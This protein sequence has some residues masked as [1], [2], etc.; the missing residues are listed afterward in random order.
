MPSAD[1]VNQLINF[2]GHHILHTQSEG[3]S[4][5][6]IFMG[7]TT[8]EIRKNFRNLRVAKK[9]FWQPRDLHAGTCNYTLGSNQNVSDL[10]AL[11]DNV[12]SNQIIATIGQCALDSINDTVSIATDAFDFLKGL[13]QNPQLL[14]Q[15]MINQAIELK[16]LVLEIGTVIS[17]LT[18]SLVNMPIQQALGLACRITSSA[19]LASAAGMGALRVAQFANQLKL[20]KSLAMI[21]KNLV[22]KGIKVSDK[23]F[24]GALRCQ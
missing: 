21:Q 19:I 3:H 22:G 5:L 9:Y 4:M 6:I 1:K 13:V 12:Y 11:K 2:E 10:K 17:D 14:W 15:K 8:A 20:I 7:F 16:N 18:S 24:S 23:F